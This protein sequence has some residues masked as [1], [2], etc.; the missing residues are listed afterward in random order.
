F[1]S[2]VSVYAAN[3]KPGAGETAPVGTIDD[4]TVEQVTGETYGPL[5]ALCE[6][7]AEGAMPGRATNIRPGL[8]VGPRDPTDRFTYWPVRVRR[9]GKVLA[10]GTPNDPVQ[11]IDVRDLA[12]FIVHAIE[13][14]AVGVFNAVGPAQ[15]LPMGDLLGA[16]RRVSGSDAELVWAD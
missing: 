6:Q 13:Q 3:D 10:P 11:I 7:A 2:T 16:C 12:D 5:K 9:G 15:P 4:E 1:I 14:S 8:I